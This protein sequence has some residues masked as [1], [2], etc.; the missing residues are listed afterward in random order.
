[1]SPDQ[2]DRLFWF[3]S[4]DDSNKIL[5]VSEAVSENY[6]DLIHAFE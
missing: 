6:K 4:V 3:D 5:E 1:M 2:S